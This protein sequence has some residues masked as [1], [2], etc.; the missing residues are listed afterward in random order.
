MDHISWGLVWSRDHCI[1][2]VGSSL[3]TVS[4]NLTMD[5]RTISPMSWK[6]GSA[7]STC[8]HQFL[9]YLGQASILE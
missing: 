2:V 4:S 8:S 9:T 7:D 3:F 5:S 6:P 1:E